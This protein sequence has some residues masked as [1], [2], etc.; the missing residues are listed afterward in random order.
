M[1]CSTGCDRPCGAVDLRPELAPWVRPQ[2]TTDLVR[3]LNAGVITLV[4]ARRYLGLHE[5]VGLCA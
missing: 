2:S 4:E 5:E 3:L 1:S